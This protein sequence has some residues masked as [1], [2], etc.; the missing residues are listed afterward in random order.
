M[1]TKASYKIKLSPRMRP[2]VGRVVR[3]G[4]VQKAFAEKIGRPAGACVKAG[5]HK[6]MKQSAIR[7]VVGACGKAQGGK[8]KLGL[9]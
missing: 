9:G 2:F 7:K 1:S 3:G 8:G 6:G 4:K 5:V